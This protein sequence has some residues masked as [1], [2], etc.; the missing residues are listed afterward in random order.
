MIDIYKK[1]MIFYQWFFSDIRTTVAVDITNKCNLKCSHCY[2]GNEY[3]SSELNDS[4]MISFMKGQRKSGKRLAILYGGEPML[5]PDICRQAGLIFDYIIVFTNGTKGFPDI[6]AR[7]VLSLDGTREVH[8]SIRGAGVYDRVMRSLEK[9]TSREPIVHITISRKNIHNISEFVEEM[10]VKRIKSIG[11]S[12]YTPSRCKDESGFFIPLEER[13]RIVD[14]IL[15]LKKK[16]GKLIGFTEAM[17]HQLRSSGAFSEWNNFNNCAVNEVCSCFN[18]DGTA[19]PCIYGTDADCSKCGCTAV[20][21]YR[22]AVKE[23]DIQS[24]LTASSLMV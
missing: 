23:Y 17:G 9:N 11:F 19:K 20:A 8:D 18:A 22:A 13:D 12:F 2:W 16:H 10:S 5:R 6:N 7:W 24:I 15:Q 14:E 1:S 4:D 21:V 3:H